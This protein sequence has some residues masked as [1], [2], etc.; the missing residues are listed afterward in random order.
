MTKDEI[1]EMARQAGAHDNGYEV[2]FVEPK[3]LERFAKLVVE[4]EREKY[5]KLIEEEMLSIKEAATQYGIPS[6][7]AAGMLLFCE[8][9]ARMVAEKEREACAKACEAEIFKVKPIYCVVAE[10]CVKVIRA[11]GQ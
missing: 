11:R 4:H 7:D 3:Y 8:E 9:F 5:T 1:I 2:Q 10:N 6:E